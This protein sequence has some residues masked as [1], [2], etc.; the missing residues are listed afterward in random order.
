MN[1]I[2]NTDGSVETVVATGETWKS[3][4]IRKAADGRLGVVAGGVDTLGDGVKKVT[5]HCNRDLEC[6]MASTVALAAGSKAAIDFASQQLIAAGGPSGDV[7]VVL[8]DAIAGG[9]ARFI[10]N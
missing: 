6:E 2:K 8:Y 9:K 4:D 3:G 7:H 10:L 5:L 1:T